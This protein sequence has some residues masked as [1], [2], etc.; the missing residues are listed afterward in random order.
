MVLTNVPSPSLRRKNCFLVISFVIFVPFCVIIFYSIPDPKLEQ[1]LQMRLSQLQVKL[2]YLESLYTSRQEELLRLSQHIEF[3][4]ETSSANQLFLGLE[5]AT[6]Q[7]GKNYTMSS[8]ILGETNPR[9]MLRMPTIYHFLPHLLNDPNS[10]RLAYLAARGRTGVSIVMGMPTVLRPHQ[11]YL[12]NTLYSLLEGLSPEE[13]ADAV[14]VVFIGETDLEKVLQIAREVE[15][16][17][18]SQIES[19]LIELIAPSPSYYPDLD[20]LPLSLGDPLE[21]VKWRSKQN[22]DY[23]Y[24]MTYC[25]N[26]GTFYL[27]LEDDILT[28]PHYFTKMKTFA[29]EKMD[30][31]E[32]WFLLDFCQLGFIGKML[33]S[34]DL[35]WLIHFLQ[36]FYSDKPVDWLLE[37]YFSMKSCVRATSESCNAVRKKKWIH[38]KPSLFQH[39]GE[40]SSLK[41]KIQKLKDKQFGKVA[42]FFPHSNPKAK[43]SSTIKHYKDYTLDRA[44]LGKT[45][46]WGLL[47]QSGDKII[48]EFSQ[49]I[50]V[51]KFYFRSGNAEHITDKLYNTTVEVLPVDPIVQGSA[52][53][54]T[55]DGYIIVGKFDLFGM[56]EGI[57]NET[58]SKISVLR[59]HVHS[60]SE[61]WTILS[62]INIIVT[63]ESR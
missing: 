37:D 16:S 21:R 45:F 5:T 14:I 55:S 43:V 53:N 29:I 12:M 28:K 13:A 26:K 8:S 17:F 50:V 34:S 62:E 15:Q 47:P 7:T 3:P 32:P 30:R 39:M 36:M 11:N 60:E 54:V 1:S 44:Y 19:G 4:N 23:A 49:P 6:K 31:K 27:Q 10:L 35:P 25:Q 9:V 24:L 46:F 20:K 18:P 61:N 40:H 59:L 22:L 57:L 33:R 48:F 56:A 38:Y 58:I 41:G 2:Q 63:E 42:L 52:W 51:K